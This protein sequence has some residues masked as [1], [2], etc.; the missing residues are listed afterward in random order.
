MNFVDYE[1]KIVVGGNMQFYAFIIIKSKFSLYIHE[2][3]G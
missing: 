2:K 1:K 3:T